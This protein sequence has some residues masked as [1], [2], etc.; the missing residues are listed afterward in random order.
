MRHPLDGLVQG[1]SKRRVLATLVVLASL[2]FGLRVYLGRGLSNDD[3][4]HGVLSLELAGS[5]LVA[6]AQLASWSGNQMV[7]GVNAPPIGLGGVQAIIGLDFAFLLCW[8]TALAV[9]CLWAGRLVPAG[10]WVAVGTG[11]AW[12]LWLAILFG[13]AENL[14]LLDL[15][16]KVSAGTPL[17]SVAPSFPEPS[18]PPMIRALALAKYGVMEAGLVY[19]AACAFYYSVGHLRRRGRIAPVTT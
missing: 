3:T 2:L 6:N 7:L 4:P 1:D 8:F 12:S 15:I 9:A 18:F 16:P 5:P 10:I 17:F 19:V 13:A 11:L 14:L